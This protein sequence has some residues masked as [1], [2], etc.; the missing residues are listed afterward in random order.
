M[1]REY[2]SENHDNYRC[3]E[4]TADQDQLL[5]NYFEHN[6]VEAFKKRLHRLYEEN[7]REKRN[8]SVYNEHI[9]K[10]DLQKLLDDL[11]RITPAGKAEYGQRPKELRMPIQAFR[12][13]MEKKLVQIGFK[14]EVAVE[15]CEN[16]Y[17]EHEHCSHS[18][19]R[20]RLVPKI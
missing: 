20:S 10:A 18:P 1:K 11:A 14:R 12:E 16:F 17:K 4:L 7:E 9:C 3:P 13:A 19:T 2:I 5:F 6:E 15:A 8:K